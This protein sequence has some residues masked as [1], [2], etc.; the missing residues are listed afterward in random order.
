[1]AICRENLIFH[2][3]HRITTIQS[4]V[5]IWFC[6]A[7]VIPFQVTSLFLAPCFLFV[8]CRFGLLSEARLS[9]NHSVY[10]VVPL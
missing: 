2:A 3:L 5:Y 8:F 1:M 9:V 10:K 6:K 4:I 7:V